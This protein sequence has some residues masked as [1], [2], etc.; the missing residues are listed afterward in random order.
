MSGALVVEAMV[1][2]IVLAIAA[3][4]AIGYQIGKSVAYREAAATVMTTIRIHDDA[5]RK[6]D[7]DDHEES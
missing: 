4:V 7:L 6:G 2:A 1:L 3:A 5:N